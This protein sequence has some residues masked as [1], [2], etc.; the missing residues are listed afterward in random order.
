MIP[1][2]SDLAMDADDWVHFF[3]DIT[4]EDATILKSLFPSYDNYRADDLRNSDAFVAAVWNG[5]AAI[6]P[7]L[8]RPLFERYKSDR[9]QD[10]EYLNTMKGALE[11][12]GLNCETAGKEFAAKAADVDIIVIDLFLG[13]TQDNEALESSVHGLSA[14]IRN[15][16]GNP[17]L[18]VLMSRSSRLEEKRKEFRDKS[19]LFESAFR[20]IRKTDLAQH[21]K[22]DRILMRLGKHYQDT[23]K[24]ATFLHAW[25]TGIGNAQKRT[26][27]LIRILDLADLAQIRQLLLTCEGEEPG[28]YLVDT[29][30]LVLQHEIEREM[31]IIDAARNLNRINAISYPPP[32]VAGSPDLQSLVYRSLF[33]NAERLHLNCGTVA[34]GDILRRS[35]SA[36]GADTVQNSLPERFSKGTPDDVFIVMTPA[37]DLQRQSVKRVLL[38]GG[39]LIKLTA[40]NWSYKESPARTTIIETSTGE[41][42]QIKWDLKHVEAVSQPEL[43]ELLAA[44]NGF[45][46]IAR[47]REAPTLE[48]QQKLLSGL[49]RVGLLAPMPATFPINLEA[50]LPNP[51]KLLFKLE[52][53]ALT[54]NQAVCF[55]G[56]NEE[57]D[58]EKVLVLCED[59]CEAVCDAIQTVNLENVHPT[60]RMLIEDLRSSEKLLILQNGIDFSNVN[61]TRFTEIRVKIPPTA[62]QGEREEIVG[63]IRRKGTWTS[64]PLNGSYLNKAGIILAASD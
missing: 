49:G 56:R 4:L 40:A 2:A 1:L 5:Q 24:L 23:L 45:R 11:A 44:E 55:V 33:Q 12:C 6:R 21:G 48:L 20:I 22:L 47:L 46:V 25:Q 37:C 32:Y 62:G 10:L 51:E 59:A 43:S 18:V 19:G 29:F 42:F 9:A 36:V 7:Q 50:Y 57:A 39:S 15:R 53:P 26:A 58:P 38:L 35:P 41:R 60:T 64:E 61:D 3:E 30:D 63:L 28:S 16:L 14:V 17:P 31:A 27:N 52:I 34:F 13:S 54:A 8:I